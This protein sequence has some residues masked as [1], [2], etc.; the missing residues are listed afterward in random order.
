MPLTEAF[1]K[2]TKPSLIGEFLSPNGPSR[3]CV[4]RYEELVALSLSDQQRLRERFKEQGRVILA[5]DGLQPD[6]GHEVLWVLRDC[7]SGEVLLARS[8]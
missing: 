5:L 7:L 3:I 8:L 4:S 1:L 2:S 6:V